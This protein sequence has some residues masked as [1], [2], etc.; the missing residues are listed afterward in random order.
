VLL[1]LKKPAFQ[2]NVPTQILE[3]YLTSKEAAQIAE[4]IIEC[5]AID[6]ARNIADDCV[7]KACES[8]KSLPS[9]KHTSALESLGRFVLERTV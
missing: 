1:A 4:K 2:L 8:L 6:D 5:G 9:S 7:Q 3:G